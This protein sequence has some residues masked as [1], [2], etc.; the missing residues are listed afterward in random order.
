MASGMDPARAPERVALYERT[1]RAPLTR[2][3]E[4]AYDWEHLPWLHRESFA[5]I[6]LEEAGA[7][8]WRARVGLPPAGSGSS[9]RIELLADRAE[10][11]YVTR[12]LEG[13]GTG[14]EIWTRLFETSPEET[15]IAVGFHVPGLEGERADA[16]GG[17]LVRLYT[18]LWD[19]DE[20]MMRER[21]RRSPV[22]KRRLPAPLSLGS[23]D[24]LRAELPKTLEFAG[25]RVRIDETDGQIRAHSLVCP[26]WMGPLGV[27][28]EDASVLVC[29]WHGYRF[30][31]RSGRSCDGHALRLRPAPEVVIEGGEVVLRSSAA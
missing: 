21:D 31:L 5:D 25:S 18:R 17:A 11:R 16:L 10:E 4:N 15:A 9:M 30:D 19:Q 6:E 14:T 8:G 12:T 27:D 13:P 23:L 2:V 3:W 29:P 26:H 22:R 20:A 24:A 7:W 1:V 28:P